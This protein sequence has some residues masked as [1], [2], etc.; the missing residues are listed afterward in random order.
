MY[1]GNRR[2]GQ[3]CNIYIIKSHDLQLLW[4]FSAKLRAYLQQLRRNQVTAGKDSVRV[5]M[6]QKQLFQHFVVF[7]MIVLIGMGSH[8]LILHVFLHTHFTESRRTLIR[9]HGRLMDA[10]DMDQMSASLGD[11]VFRRQTSSLDVVAL[12]CPRSVLQK[13]LDRN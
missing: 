1:G 12:H 13:S 9:R 3:R 4:H 2:R 7:Q 8:H 5:R 6:L 10:T 11:Q